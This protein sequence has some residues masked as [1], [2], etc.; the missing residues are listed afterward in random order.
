MSLISRFDNF[1]NLD[2]NEVKYLGLTGPKTH[3]ESAHFSKEN[4]NQLEAAPNVL[5]DRS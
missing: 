4:A 5:A 1:I 3:M 2:L